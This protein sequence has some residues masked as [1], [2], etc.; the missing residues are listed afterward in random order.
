MCGNEIKNFGFRFAFRS[1]IRNFAIEIAKF[2]HLGRKK[3]RVSFVLHSIFRNF[4]AQMRPRARK[5]W[6][7]SLHKKQKLYGKNMALVWQE[8]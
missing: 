1:L 5:T 7:E 8:G 6:T 2:L 3:K 4:V